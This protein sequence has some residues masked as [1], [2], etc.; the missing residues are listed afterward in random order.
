MD[1]QITDNFLFENLVIQLNNKQLRVNIYDTPLGL[2]WIEALKD[3]LKQ[4][5]VLEKNFCFLGWPDSKRNINFLCNELNNTI[6]QI[7]CFNSLNHWRVK[8]KHSTN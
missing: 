8:H 3:N 1:K 7:N 4:Q 2:R 5:R 6:F